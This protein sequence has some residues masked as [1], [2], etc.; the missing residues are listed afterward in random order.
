MFWECGSRGPTYSK[1]EWDALLHST[2]LQD[3]I[4]AVQRARD[5]AG[6]L[7]LPVPTWE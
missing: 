7:D 6:K 2:N 5:R 4:L 1:T 3:Q